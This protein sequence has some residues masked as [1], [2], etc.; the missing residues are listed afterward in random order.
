MIKKIINTVILAVLSVVYTFTQTPTPQP[1]PTQMD[2]TIS[3]P[4]QIN[5][6]RQSGTDVSKLLITTTLETILTEA[7][8]QTANY[9]EAFKN[10]LATETKTYERYDKNGDEKDRTVIESNF[11][12]YQSSKDENVSSELRNIVKVDGK[13]VPEGQARAD[14]FLAELQKSKT[15]ENELEKIQDEGSRYDK[16]LETSGLTLFE[17]FVL[18]DK[19]RPYFDFKLLGSENY[20][21][22]EVFI[23]SYQQMK[24]SPFI[25]INEKKSKEK[26]VKANNFDANLPGSLKKTD[27]FLRGKLWIDARTYQLRREEQQLTVQ[28]ADPLIASET[29]F[30]YQPSEYEILVPKQISLLYNSIKKASKNNQF[31]AVKDTKITF[32]YSQFKKSEVDVQIVDEP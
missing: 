11:F 16:S 3:K 8:K 13:L 4:G 17:A 31:N 12:V 7:G 25:K 22:N 14:R 19:L 2:T 23:V 5:L 1:S 28:T 21:G 26:D 9:R 6:P 15:V 20:Q 29:I 32:D 10:L 30:E 18:T 24:K 27:T